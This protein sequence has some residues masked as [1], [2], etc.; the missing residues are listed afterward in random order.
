MVYNMKKE[1]AAA[2]GRPTG[3]SALIS[4]FPVGKGLDPSAFGPAGCPAPTGAAQIFVGRAF[5]S[6]SPNI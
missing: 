6:I 3:C 4:D 2:S 5:G 1:T